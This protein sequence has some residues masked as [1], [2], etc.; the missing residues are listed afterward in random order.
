MKTKEWIIGLSAGLCSGWMIRKVVREPSVTKMKYNRK[1][2]DFYETGKNQ[3][4]DI[5]A[6]KEKLR[7][8]AHKNLN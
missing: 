4:E 7:I 8:E 2:K 6:T 3:Y 5:Q 1:K